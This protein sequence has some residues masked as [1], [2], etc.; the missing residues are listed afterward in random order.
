MSTSF[1]SSVD[2][3]QESLFVFKFAKIIEDNEIDLR[4]K[5]HVNRG[6]IKK[7]QLFEN[8]HRKHIENGGTQ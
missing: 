5:W 1:R 6:N 4:N 3:N 8:L 2:G 7:F